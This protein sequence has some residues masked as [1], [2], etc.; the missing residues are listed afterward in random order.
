[1]DDH[2]VALGVLVATTLWLTLLTLYSP[3]IWYVGLSVY[4]GACVLF[5]LRGFKGDQP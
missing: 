3:D 2:R 5:A 4:C 1:M